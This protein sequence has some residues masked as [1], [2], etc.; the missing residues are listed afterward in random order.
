[1]AMGV[2]RVVRACR[3]SRAAQAHPPAADLSTG[4]AANA[5]TAA[6]TTP[7]NAATDSRPVRVFSGLG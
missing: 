2:S 3:R 5:C 6:A 7:S 1:M 4:R